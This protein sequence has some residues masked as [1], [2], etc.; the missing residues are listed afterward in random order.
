MITADP[1]G[2]INHGSAQKEVTGSSVPGS[3]VSRC[4]SQV[5][6]CC[7]T[8]PSIKIPSSPRIHHWLLQTRPADVSD[9]V[10]MGL[11]CVLSRPLP[12]FYCLVM[13]VNLPLPHYQWF[14][15]R[16]C[17]CL[18]FSI[19][20]LLSIDRHL[21]ASRRRLISFLHRLTRQQAPLPH[22]L[23]LLFRTY[24]A[25]DTASSPTTLTLTLID[26]MFCCHYINLLIMNICTCH[27]DATS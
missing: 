11:L 6:R 14:K 16:D 8:S 17:Q 3:R 5:V 4:S 27:V 12:A 15:Y 19:V 9:L 21:I 18:T 2:A 1:L 24:I 26:R 25:K 20:I 23:C 13:M 7:R 10:H 22:F